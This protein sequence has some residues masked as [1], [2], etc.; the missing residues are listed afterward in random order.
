MS[1][2][3]YSHWEM[4]QLENNPNVVKVSERSITY[5]PL[6]KKVAI[7]EYQKGKFPTRSLRSTA[8]IYISLESNNLND[9]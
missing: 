9:A 6:F 7:Q 8:L 4:K 2:Q 1:K 3:L 5:H